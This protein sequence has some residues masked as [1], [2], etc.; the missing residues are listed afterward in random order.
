MANPN[1]LNITSIK[2]EKKTGT[3]TTSYTGFQIANA[4]GSNELVKVISIYLTNRS[5]STVSIDAYLVHNNSSAYQFADALDLPPETTLQLVSKD[6]PLYVM[7]N[8]YVGLACSATTSVD[9]V[10]AY[11]VMG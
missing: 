1:L 6:A 9:A 5:A 11:E 8:D 4:S 3:L 2:G 7:E 10:C